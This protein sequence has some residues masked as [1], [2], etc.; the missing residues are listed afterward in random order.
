MRHITIEQRFATANYI[1]LLVK[2]HFAVEQM[3]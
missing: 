2:E 1:K 3:L